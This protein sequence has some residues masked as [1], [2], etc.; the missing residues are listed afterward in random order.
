MSC[1]D[2]A[3]GRRTP[4]LHRLTLYLEMYFYFLSS[5]PG[6]EGSFGKAH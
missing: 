1:Y 2:S 5:L 6:K 4:D 3:W